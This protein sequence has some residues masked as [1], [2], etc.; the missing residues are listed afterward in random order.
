MGYDSLKF[1]VL[2]NWLAL[3][4][5]DFASRDEAFEPLEV[6]AID[7][8]LFELS[9]RVKNKQVLV[10]RRFFEVSCQKPTTDGAN[11]RFLLRKCQLL[12]LLS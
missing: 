6:E 3:C 7:A 5:F 1:L 2:E 10:H 8:N 11:L 4:V 9:S 12:F